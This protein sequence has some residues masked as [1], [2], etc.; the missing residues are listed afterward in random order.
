MHTFL[1]HTKS[2]RELYTQEHKENKGKPTKENVM[3]KQCTRLNGLTL[4]N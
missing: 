2:I 3:I 1:K 4:K